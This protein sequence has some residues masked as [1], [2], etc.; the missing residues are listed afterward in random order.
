MTTP[1]S[2]A[3]ISAPSSSRS[4]TSVRHPI[5]STLPRCLSTEAS[6]SGGISALLDDLDLYVLDIRDVVAEQLD[7]PLPAAPIALDDCL[8]PL[9][10]TY[11]EAAAPGGRSI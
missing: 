6:P 8:R 4:A 9:A 2:L 1:S 7:E 3:A 11:I 10:F 5:D